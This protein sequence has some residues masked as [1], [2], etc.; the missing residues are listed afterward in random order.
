VFTAES[1]KELALGKHSKAVSFHDHKE[2][3]KDY[4]EEKKDY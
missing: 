2:K 4:H 3:K 1:V